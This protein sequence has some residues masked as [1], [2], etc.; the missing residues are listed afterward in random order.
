MRGRL[1]ALRAAARAT[2]AVALAAACLATAP[3]DAMR[4]PIQDGQHA[5]DFEFGWWK[6]HLRRLVQPLSGSRTWVTYDG[7]SVVYKVWNGRANVG[8]LELVNA[9]ARIEGL[10]LRLY[11][12]ATRQWSISFANSED[13]RLGTAM[14]GRFEHGRG[15]FYDREHFR[16]KTIGVRFVFSDI[17]PQSF[18]F[19]QAFSAD[20]GR[21][22]E[23]NWIADFTRERSRAVTR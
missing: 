16:G 20:G 4:S 13:G 6:A 19:V 9:T 15:V 8:E 18:R 2:C 7:T 22:W 5:F 10:T 11:D 23:T 1:G 17:A 12:P 3:V 21:T 14:V